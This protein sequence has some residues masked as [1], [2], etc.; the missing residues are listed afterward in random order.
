MSAWQTIDTAPKD[1]TPIL[2]LSNGE[3]ATVRWRVEGGGYWDLCVCGTSASDGEWWPSLWMPLPE[4]AGRTNAGCTCQACGALF[5]GDLLVPDD[6][7]EKIKPDNSALGAGLLCPSCIMG[8]IRDLG[9][10]T[11]ARAIDVDA[12]R[13]AAQEPVAFVLQRRPGAPFHPNFDAGDFSWMDISKSDWGDDE[14]WVSVPLY[15]HPA[16]QQREG[17]SELEA[18]RKFT[19]YVHQRLDDAGVEADPPSPHREE[20]CRIGGRL[21]IVLANP[22]VGPAL[23]PK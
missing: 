8:R 13:E 20:G 5:T 17:A 16:P 10:W 2:G 6:I 22:L 7:W 12:P 19:A 14:N 23:T 21:D 3:M 1:G 18:L 4:A 15:T 9:I 11:A